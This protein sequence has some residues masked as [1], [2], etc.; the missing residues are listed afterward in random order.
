MSARIAIRTYG[1]LLLMTLR[2]SPA[3][4]GGNV[5]YLVKDINPTGF[6]SPEFMTKVGDRLFF[7]A[8]DGIHG[9]ELWVSDGTEVGTYMILD[10]IPGPD[11]SV[12]QR[13]AE[14]NGKALFQVDD[15]IDGMQWYISDGT[16]S[17]TV[18]VGNVHAGGPGIALE[19][20]GF[21]G[22]YAEQAGGTVFFTGEDAAHGLELWKTDG[23]P[24]GTTLVMDITPGP[25]DALIQSFQE[26]GP[27]LF[28]SAASSGVSGLNL[29]K[30]DGTTDG[31]IRLTTNVSTIKTIDVNGTAFF[32]GWDSVAGEELWVS[33]GTSEGTHLVKDINPGPANSTPL[34]LT[35][36]NGTLFFTSF[37]PT[38][39]RELW[40][41]DGT[42]EGTNMVV[43]LNPSAS[44]GI[45]ELAS[46]G[47]SLLFVRF[48]PDAGW[49]LWK[50]DGT[51][52][53]TI[54]LQTVGPE[55]VEFRPAFLTLVHGK[56]FFSNDDG[57]HGRELWVSNGTSEGTLMVADVVPGADG[58]TP[59]QLISVG[60]KLFFVGATAESGGPEL[61][62][63]DATEPV[64]P[65]T[66]SLTLAALCV[67]LIG[68]GAAI[69]HRR[70]LEWL[71]RQ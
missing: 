7:N 3:Y 53:G 36:V 46:L 4:A 27:H 10:L 51:S 33:D 35:N 24:Q 5:P 48:N 23:T 1:V 16:A 12:P 65:A 22:Y 30:S 64:I 14:L 69:V 32:Q 18:S 42:D 6:S 38:A 59:T 9:Q 20:C 28:F 54:A 70:K 60:T 41:S 17:G 67:G 61:F 68:V 29:W 63:F 19:T 21:W 50:S 2:A 11:G 43:D 31:T 47:E 57:V 66:S 44:G 39:G 55:T 71:R 56:L 58:V 25:L 52:Q 62:A 45:W 37:T 49:Q 15:N 13:M 34:L 26:V 40:K 8:N